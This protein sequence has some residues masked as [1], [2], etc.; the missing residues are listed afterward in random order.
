LIGGP[1]EVFMWISSAY[2]LTSSIGKHIH[3][4]LING[5]YQLYVGETFIYQTTDRNEYEFINSAIEHAVRSNVPYLKISY[6]VDKY[7]S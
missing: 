3:M 7:K 4:K 2:G 1:T 5:N 6:L